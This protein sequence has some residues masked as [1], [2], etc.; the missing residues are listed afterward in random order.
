MTLIELYQLLR[1][2]GA[3]S[4]AALL[5]RQAHWFAANA[6][7]DPKT[8]EAL[9]QALSAFLAKVAEPNPN[10]RTQDRLYRITEHARLSVERLFRTLNESPRREHALLPVRAVRELDAA[11]FVKLS[12]RPGRNIREKLA[13]KPYLQA[14]RRFQSID[15]PENRLLKAY[16]SR[17]AELLE[18][19]KECLHE[20]EDELL[21]KIQSWLFTDESRA[22]G[23]WDNLP[24]NNTL[25]SHRDYRR[26]WDAWRWLQALD[27]DIARDFSQIEARK[28]TM[29]RWN[30]YGRMYRTG[31]HYV[32]EMPVLFDYERF[33]IRT[34]SPEPFV[35]K[36][37]RKLQR[38]FAV[39]SVTEPACIDLSRMHPCYS[40]TA[41]SSHVL[42]ENYLWQQW[43]NDAGSVDIAL[44]NSDAACLHPDAQLVAS[45]DLFF[46]SDM[47][48][49]HLDRAARAFASR[50]REVFGSDTLIWLVPDFLNDFDLE[51]VRRNVNAR[52]PCAE[53]L[54]RSV[55]AVFEQV[56]YA[57]IKGKDFAVVVAD[58]IGGKTSITKLIAWFDRELQRL[59]PET[60]GYYWKR[61]PPVL[62]SSRDSARTAER[63]QRYGMATVT[64]D[65]QWFEEARPE[66]QGYIDASALKRDP[67][68]E[69]FAFC[70]N[71]TNSPVR[72]GMRLHALQQRAGNIPLWRDQIPELSIKVMKDG[73][74]QRF[75]LVSRGRTVRPFRGHSVPIPV[76]EK[77]TLPAG[78]AFYQ[79][80]LFQGESARELG[81]SARLDSPAFPLK[82]DTA[83]DL[84]LTFQYGDDEPYSLV[85]EPLD[86][87][88]PPVRATWQRTV[89][90]I[91]TDAPGPE[92]PNPISW[93]DLRRWRDA[94]G[95]EID[96]P[97]W[98]I[99]SLTR[100]IELIP[101]RRRISISSSWSSKADDSGST[102]WFAFAATENGEKCYC[103][104]RNFD[105]PQ[106]GDLNALFPRGTVLYGNIR[107]THGGLAAFDIST[108][109][110]MHYSAEVKRRLIS[111]RER[112]LQNRMSTIWADGRSVEDDE[113]SMEFRSKFDALIATLMEALPAELIDRK[114]MFLLACLHRNTLDQCVQWV[115]N[116]IGGGRIRDPSAVGFALGDVSQKW[117]QYVF[118][119][120]AC[121]PGNDAI[122]VFAY[123]VWREQQFVNL[124]SLGELRALLDALFRRLASIRPVA[125]GNGREGERRAIRNWVRATAEPL[126]LLLG[127]LRTR[128]SNDPEIRMLLQPHQKITKQ[129]A[130]QIDRVEKIVAESNITLFSRVQINIQK[131]EGVRSP[132]LLYALRLYLTG[133]D[134]A[135]AIHITSISDSA[136]D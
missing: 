70:I 101:C 32:A 99:G 123:A 116:Q 74:Y 114:M 3:R 133:D 97:A 11:C 1:R 112:S 39:K 43:R 81:F 83:C 136:D 76:D 47:S 127:L 55:A 111:F 29:R 14:V 91:V 23:R 64:P 88:F 25:L 56:D 125:I 135:N 18:L 75:Y 62:L 51:I 115:T 107:K 134:G 67:R 131:P 58:T 54:P 59:L 94:E 8:G 85:F 105:A 80:P 57:K 52:F 15:I 72:G 117:Q 19:R 124:F 66:R 73:R 90:E 65:G 86:R 110:V 95:K 24:P 93:D 92:Y 77:F 108:E 6:E 5:I 12:T 41:S 7:F 126:E 33:T 53:P 40:D 118:D 132:D 16:V 106:D 104:S 69:Q 28:E 103:N 100:L 96:L 61:C 44:F 42:S 128:A 82:S 30:E 38:S 120:L 130:E 48:P 20:S 35:T 102:Y 36:A 22:I 31:S 17:L 63:D 79:F 109:D 87:S 9:P 4:E 68:I 129:F 49:D 121:N 13:G 119:Q 122:S 89:E 2:N 60:K 45:P 50:L 113:C 71:V 21:P 37:L 46:A 27:D 84:I 98:L 26:V 34:W 10:G 78:K